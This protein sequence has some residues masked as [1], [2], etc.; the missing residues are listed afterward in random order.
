MNGARMMLAMSC[1]DMLYDTIEA[2]PSAMMSIAAF[3]GL[4]LR[5]SA[6]SESRLPSS[7]R[8]RE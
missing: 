2:L 6:I 5:A 1:S 3:T 7:D 8:S 4:T